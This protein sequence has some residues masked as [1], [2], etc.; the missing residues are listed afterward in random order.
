M[1]GKGPAM[2]FLRRHCLSLRLTVLLTSLGIIVA[3]VGSILGV[4]LLQSEAQMRQQREE[5]ERSNLRSLFHDIL[6]RE[7]SAARSVQA[8]QRLYT[9]SV[10]RYSPFHDMDDHLKT[11]S[12]NPLCEYLGVHELSRYRANAIASGVA[13]RN[14]SG[15]LA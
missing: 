1:G 12:F 8:L 7:T 2:A 4:V 9:S 6:E 11:G 14:N 13:D 10:Q 5:T 15:A 3:I